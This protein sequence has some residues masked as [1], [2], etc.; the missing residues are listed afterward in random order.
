MP[1]TLKE[2][3]EARTW[4]LQHYADWKAQLR[5][6][7]QIAAG[8]WSVTLE[9]ATTESSEPLIQ[10]VYLNS[11]EDK[12]ATAGASLPT[13]FVPVPVGTT[14]DKGE[15]QAQKRK[16]VYTSYWDR[17][18]LKRNLKGYYRDWFHYGAAYT[19]PRTDWYSLTGERIPSSERAPYLVRLDPR[20]A[21]P[22]SHNGRGELNQIL[23]ARRRRI[24]EVKAHWG[25]NNL[26]LQRI[27]ASRARQGLDD[28][29][30]VEE[31]WYVDDSHWAV[32]FAD[33][34]VTSLNMSREVQRTYMREELKNA[35]IEWAMPPEKHMLSACPVT[36]A[37]RD[38]HDGA[39]RG[40]IENIIPTL[41]V[42]QNFMYKLL[43]DLSNSVYAPV[44]LD[45]VAN[46][47]EYGPGAVL[48]GTGE[49]TARVEHARP[50]VNFEAGQVVQTL[51]QD[52]H[53]EAKW[54]VQRSGNPDAS[55]VS[56]RGVNALTGAFNSELAWAQSDIESLLE[57]S[58]MMLAN[59][60][61]LHCA[62][63]KRIYGVES[64]A[65]YSTIYDPT[66]LFNFKDGKGDFRNKVTYGDRTGLDEQ[67]HLTKL[68]LIKN[69]GGMSTRTFVTKAGGSDD[70]LQEER[71]IAIEN[72]TAMFYQGILPQAI[73]AG[74]V[75]Q[76]KAFVDLIDGDKVTV[77]EAVLQ[78]I[79]QMLP[80]PAAGGGAPGGQQVGQQ[81]PFLQQASLD[82][83][84]I[85]GSAQGLPA[86][87]GV[88][89]GLRQTLPPTIRRAAAGAGT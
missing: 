19:M 32:M 69:M 33:S 48:E 5:V 83:G 1:P 71:D 20:Q 27:Q 6:N 85:P 24:R 21:Y 17:S 15:K 18:G 36:E 26:G 40:A 75:S 63:R 13:I 8:D 29:G 51:V 22:L 9:D 16:W 66:V 41:K 67:Q 35:N 28:D 45:N 77:R 30:Y 12:I 47:D 46:V 25:V 3:R 50:P 74:D 79:Q 42:A 68:A 31:I 23:F 38:T 53:R 86:P 4:A 62:G 49:G 7:D 80:P 10:N 11:L 2:M 61:A 39:Y 58:N 43:D 34:L 89:D 72:L 81:D 52:A 76:L 88:S 37:K 64:G 60:D 44:L 59:L 87:P 70:P 14:K 78:T 84:G 65:G 82:A 73:A 55:I 54:P 56:A 57:R